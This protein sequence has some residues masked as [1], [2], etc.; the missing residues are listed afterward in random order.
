MPATTIRT[1]P[2]I[3]NYTRLEEHQESTPESFF[4]GKPVLYYHGIAAKAWLPK[5]QRGSLPFFPQ[6]FEGSATIPEGVSVD[7]AAED[8]VEQQV[9]LFVN[10]E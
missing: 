7:G 1:P 6:D 5:S 2:A 10:T 9:E 4:G 3:E 8:T